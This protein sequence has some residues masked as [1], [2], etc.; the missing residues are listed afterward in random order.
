[1]H[2]RLAVSENTCKAT[3]SIKGEKYAASRT[4]LGKVTPLDYNRPLQAVDSDNCSP[5]QQAFT[6]LEGL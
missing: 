5:E 3:V 4:V 1:M 6:T 2:P